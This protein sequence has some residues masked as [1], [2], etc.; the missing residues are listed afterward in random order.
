MQLYAG[1]DLHSSSNHI[2]IINEQD[3]RIYRNKLANDPARILEVL[4]PFKKD[5]KG[6]VVE[7]T[8]NW[9]WL[10][11]AL[12][13]QGI[14]ATTSLGGANA[15]LNKTDWSPLKDK[16][17][18]IWPDNDE[19]GRK[20]ATEVARASIEAGAVES[21][22]VEI[23]SHWPPKWD[24]A[25]P[26]PA[27]ESHGILDRLRRDARAPQHRRRPRPPGHFSPSPRRGFSC[28]PR[29]PF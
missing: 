19:A 3:R 10:V 8:F 28:R 15:P 26:V 4:E 7:S 23:P 17:I 20:A 18:L 14:V 25:D 29:W 13:E 9:Y 21:R 1:I 2:G 16:D 5:L 24:L 12:M 22:V 11:D 27:G 6:V